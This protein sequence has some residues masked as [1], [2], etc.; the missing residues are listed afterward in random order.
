MNFKNQIGKNILYER[1]KRGISADEIANLLSMGRKSILR[2]ER[3]ER[4]TSIENLYKLATHFDM[5]LD[6]LVLKKKEVRY[7]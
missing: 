4:C 5:S 3:G 1:E 7:E 2:I 6:E